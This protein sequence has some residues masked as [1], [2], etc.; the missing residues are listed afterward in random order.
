ML[1]KHYVNYLSGEIVSKFIGVLALWT[2]G[3]FMTTREIADYN[4]L[5][6]YTELFSILI[7]FGSDANL[8]ENIHRVKKGLLLNINYFI[9]SNVFVVVSLC[10]VLNLLQMVSISPLIFCASSIMA[11]STIARVYLSE[12]FDSGSV[13][14][15][16]IFNSGINFSLIV[17]V[18]IFNTLNAIILLTIRS[19]AFLPGIRYYLNAIK[20]QIDFK[21]VRFTNLINSKSLYIYGFPLVASSIVSLINVYIVR[22]IS[23]TIITIDEQGV[24]VFFNLIII[25]LNM[26]LNSFNQAWAP[27]LNN[28]FNNNRENFSNRLQYYYAISVYICFAFVLLIFILSIILNNIDISLNGYYQHKSVFLVMLIANAWNIPYIIISPLL[29]ITGNKN[30]ILIVNLILTALAIPLSYFLISSFI[31]Y[32]AGVALSFV[33]FFNFILT[34]YFLQKRCNFNPN[35]FLVLIVLAVH[36]FIITYLY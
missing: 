6:F 5:L 11:L 12:T 24:F 26:V 15:F 33:S 1:A 16:L 30:Y 21:D 13:K 20:K 36:I 19:I 34:T 31:L 7:L 9:L 29:I 3:Y 4:N 35:Y 25:N 32:G 23:D 14:K 27:D 22:L 17:I 18:G 10:M 8:R 2:I 28:R